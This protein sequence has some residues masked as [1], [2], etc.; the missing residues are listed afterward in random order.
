MGLLSWLSGDRRGTAS[1]E[2]AASGVDEASGHDGATAAPPATAAWRELPPVQ[3]TTAHLGLLTDPPRFQGALDTWQ[4]VTLT[5]RL[6]HLVSPL[7]PSGV[8]YG[9]ANPV[10]PPTATEPAASSSGSGT[11]WPAVPLQRT[12]AGASLPTVV[13]TDTAHARRSNGSLPTADAPSAVEAGTADPPTVGDLPTAPAPL[14]MSTVPV[15]RST[16]P[17]HP[18]G[19]GEPLTELPSTA[20]RAPAARSGSSATSPDTGPAEP[21]GTGSGG[22]GPRP[23]PLLAE[24]PLLPSDAGLPQFPDQSVAQ[25]SAQP[26]ASSQTRQSAQPP[27]HARPQPPSS[28]P[29][30]TFAPGPPVVRLQRI[31]ESDGRPPAADAVLPTGPER[32]TALTGE[33]PLPVYSGS[34]SAQPFLPGPSVVPVRWSAPAGPEGPGHPA[35]ADTART[36]RTVQTLQRAAESEPVAVSPHALGAGGTSDDRP[37]AAPRT[38]PYSS[39]RSAAFA[40]PADAGSVAVASGVA[41]R[42]ADGSVLFGTPPA[43]PS[44]PVQRRAESGSGADG[45][46]PEPAA[47]PASEPDLEPVPAPATGTGS[48]GPGSGPPGGPQEAGGARQVDDELVRALFAPLSRLLKTELRLDR[49]RAGFLINTRY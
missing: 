22:S 11:A 13:T 47:G 38:P 33:R 29:V 1:R 35:A 43:A 49:E 6:G 37:G 17:P 8:L 27:E 9:V 24:N 7:A 40:G 31:P 23:G 20:Q 2:A 12:V 36:A 16:A 21:A 10:V 32:T 41:Q 44:W 46:P 14:S 39:M 45:P 26:P 42:L 15:Q 30:P 18:V 4:D 48:R 34:G 5:G 25:R 19:V 3:R 28:P